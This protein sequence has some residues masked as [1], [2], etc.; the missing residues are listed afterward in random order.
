MRIL[1]V[2]TWYPGPRDRVAGVFVADQAQALAA[3]HEVA[4]I[5]P[6]PIGL[7]ALSR[8]GL[9]KHP[10]GP[11]E[12]HGVTVLRREFLVPP[13][14]ADGGRVAARRCARAVEAA[15][16]ELL[17]L[18]WGRPDV[19]HAHVVH[20]GGWAAAELARK[21]GVPFVLTEH[22]SPFSRHFALGPWW[23]SAVRSTLHSADLVIAVSEGLRRQILDASGVDCVVVPNAFDTT[24]FSPSES[25]RDPG[26]TRVAAVGLL[27]R[28]KGV[29]VLLRALAQ[30][31]PSLAWELSIGGDGP[32]M[33]ALNTLCDDLGLHDRVHFLGRLD[34]NGV[35]DLLRASDAFVLASRHENLPG[36][37]AEAMLT[38]LPI[39][40]TRCGGPEYMLSE[41]LGWLVPVDD[42]D[43]LTDAMRRV[44]LGERKAR[45]GEVRAV[46]VSRYGTSVVV[47]R[48][49]RLY[50]DAIGV[51]STPT[52]PGPQPGSSGPGS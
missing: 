39:I 20:P 14:R 2:A 36:V 47:D 50:S 48:L 17:N 1:V 22:T 6:Y 46:A 49:T 18:G 9:P 52:V 24:Y 37:V 19:V 35:R 43:A 34:R 10:G 27:T 3:Q 30:I 11:S 5:A 16:D 23:A 28:Q 15:Y 21:L 26:P 45:R 25:P 44:F 12:E 13:T 42:E 7:R 32:E 4:V 40:A 33:N 31:E 38:D 29:D 41:E 51:P 8:K